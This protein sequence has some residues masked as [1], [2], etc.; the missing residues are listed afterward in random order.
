MGR[1][2]GAVASGGRIAGAEAPEAPAVIVVAAA[3]ADMD[4]AVI[5]AVGVTGAADVTGRP[6]AVRATGS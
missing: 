2:G 6:A 5:A 4:A 1:Q 3:P